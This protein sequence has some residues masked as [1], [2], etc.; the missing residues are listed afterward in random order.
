[1]AAL[2]FTPAL[3]LLPSLPSR[4]SLFRKSTPRSLPSPAAARSPQR[5]SRAANNAGRARVV[6]AAGGAGEDGGQH[7]TSIRAS[8]LSAPHPHLRPPVPV[9]VPSAHQ[10]LPLPAHGR[11]GGLSWPPPRLPHPPFMYHPPP[12]V[13]LTLLSCTIRLPTSPSPSFHVPS[14]SPR[15]PHPPFMYHPPPHVSLTLPL[16]C[17]LALPTSP[18]PSLSTGPSPSLAAPL[19]PSLSL[20]PCCSSH[21][22]LA[23]SPAITSVPVLDPA[24]V[25]AA[26][27]RALLRHHGLAASTS[28]GL[29]LDKDISSADPHVAARGEQLLMS[30]LAVAAGIGASH[31]TGVTFSAIAKYPTP[32]PGGRARDNMVGA[33]RRVAARAADSGVTL[34]LEV[35]NRYESNV[36]N[37]A[38]Q[39][40]QLV[41]EV[42]HSNVVVHLDSY[43]MN[44]EESSLADAVAL[45]GSKLGYVHI[46]ESHRGYLGSGTVDFPQL[47]RALA[48][49]QYRGPITFESFSSE[50][51]SPTLSNTL[52]VWRNLGAQPVTCS[53]HTTHA[54]PRMP[55]GLPALP[56]IQAHLPTTFAHHVPSFPASLPSSPLSTCASPWRAPHLPPAP[57]SWDDSDHLAAHAYAFMSSQWSAALRASRPPTVSV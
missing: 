22:P 16:S 34:G 43:H 23:P 52:A 13:S 39:A 36:L 50:V 48:R 5:Q 20:R 1:M 32:F 25:D 30:A 28:L 24:T 40:V 10:C 8:P 21:P 14:A 7:A 2:I 38:A 11:Q 4:A 17:T 51:V 41:E 44:I 49:A 53:S 6:I 26:H 15:L 9:A 31:L 33:L 12:H 45:C 18:S 3:H 54:A 57:P 29:S 19:S 56:S 42:G 35:V 27:T 47:F 55:H 46:G 37:T